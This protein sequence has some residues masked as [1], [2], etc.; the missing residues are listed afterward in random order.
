MSIVTPG[1][2]GRGR[3]APELPPGQYLVHDFPVLSAGPTPVIDAVWKTRVKATWENRPLS[4]VSRR[5]L[6]AL[7]S[8]RGSGQDIDDI[9]KLQSGRTTD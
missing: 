8:L 2:R 5:G 4:V 1:F 6:I 7:K 9:R 3:A